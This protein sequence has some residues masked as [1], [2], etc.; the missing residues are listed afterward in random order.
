[1]PILDQL[2]YDAAIVDKK[3]YERELAELQLELLSAELEHRERGA[4]VVIAFEGW[5]AAGKGGAIKRL[6][7]KLDPR[8]YQVWSISAPTDEEKR[9][10]YLWRFWRRLPERGRWTV[11]DRTWY[12]RVLVE[13]VE[14]FAKKKE[15]KRAFRE[16]NEFERMLVDDGVILVKLFLAITKDE[17]LAR[18]KQRETDPYKRYKIGA[19]DWR[20]REHWDAYVEAAEDAFAQ[21]STD[22]A[23]WTVIGANRKWNAR[24]RVLRAVLKALGHE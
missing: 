11:F 10:H 2:D 17:Q 6:T 16:I 22:Y 7:E 3:T 9:H 13:R 24:I 8:G 18:F 14:E 12:G 19:E 4:S 23:P 1:M 21:T 15:W 20:N 5:D